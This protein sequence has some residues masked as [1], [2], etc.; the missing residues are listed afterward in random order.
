MRTDPLSTLSLSLPAGWALEPHSCALQRLVFVDWRQP[1]VRQLHAHLQA[2]EASALESDRSWE[3]RVRVGLPPELPRIECR[4]GPVLWVERPGRDGRPDQRW[5]I[6]RGPR[7]DAVIEQVGVPLGGALA[8]PELQ[9]AVR[10]LDVGINRQLGERF[11]KAR[12]LAHLHAARAAFQGQD[13]QGALR[14]LR[15]AMHV[16]RSTWLHSLVGAPLPEVPAAVAVGEVLLRMSMVTG[17]SALVRQASLVLLRC[18][19]SLHQMSAPSVPAQLQ[20]VADLLGECRAHLASL[21]GAPPA[22][23]DFSELLMRSA[24]AQREAVDLLRHSPRDADTPAAE[25]A[26]E[27]A[28]SAAARA[29]LGLFRELPPGHADVL[30]ARGVVDP[31]AQLAAANGLLRVEALRHLV[32]AGMLHAAGRLQANNR[33][34]RTRCAN[35]LLAARDLAHASPCPEHEAGVAMAL[36]LLAG[37]MLGLGDETSLQEVEA[38]LDEA[39]RLLHAIAGHAELKAQILLN[40]AWLQYY[41]RR[42]EAGLATADRALAAAQAASS[43]RL[44]RAARSLRATYLGLNGQTA[45]AAAEARAALDAAHDD[46]ASTHW[47]NLAVVLHGAGDIAGATQALR[48]GLA[49]A[50][51]DQPLAPEVV[52]LL[53]VAAACLEPGDPAG[54]RAATEAAQAVMD[55]LRIG[56]DDAQDLIGFDDAAHHRQLAGSLVQRQ[57]EAGD[58]MGALASADRHRARALLGQLAARPRA[59]VRSASQQVAPAAP[60]ASA[61][62]GEQMAFIDAAARHVLD[63]AGAP[64]ARDGAA[65]ADLVARHGRMALVCH[66]SSDRLLLFL[67]LPDNGRVGIVCAEAGLP[68]DELLALTERLREQLGIVVAARAARGLAPPQSVEDLDAALSDSDALE[69]ADHELDQL[70]QALHAALLAPLLAHLQPGRPLVVLPYRELAVVPLSLLRDSQGRPL[71]DRHALSVLPSLA[72]LEAL[73]PAPG[74]AAHAVVVGDPLLDAHS[75]LPPLPGAAAEARAVDACLKAAGIDTRLLMHE[76][77]T[78]RALRAAASGARIVH[79]ACHAA[80]RARASE[81]PLFLAPE[82]PDDGL[83]LPADIADLRLDGALVVLAACQSGL[84]RATADGVLGLGRAFLQAGARCVLLSLWRVSDTATRELMTQFYAALAGSAE[85]PALDAA[86]ALA[87]AQRAGRAAFGDAAALWGPWLL[88]GD[89][90]WRLRP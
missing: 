16:A 12:L 61:G 28:M 7:F 74:P 30:A 89:G 22:G 13:A 38:L 27:D 19:A 49:A 21:A 47:L 44:V 70:L 1:R 42:A 77:A 9:E 45:L 79:L 82:P 51:A 52:R 66:P 75:G 15:C 31:V 65:L 56:L 68:L 84:G 43:E 36:N 80:L 29:A 3:A 81:S 25:A 5:A 39:G 2:S 8:T 73:A 60:P 41:Q 87:A 90:G 11:E 62:L 71:S 33:L 78:E 64:M 24:M 57:L 4:A 55:A 14:E 86:A 59:P 26:V 20:H 6:V 53:F 23:N 10:T 85:A 69:P 63:A 18:R 67:V 37:A 35:L 72:T 46:A 40:Q 17:S 88:V 34:Q 48:D 83:L 54:A 76:H 32:S 58:F 50:I